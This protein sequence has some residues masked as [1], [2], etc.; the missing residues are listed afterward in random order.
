MLYKD[1]KGT[2]NFSLD[3]NLLGT[4]SNNSLILERI[5]LQ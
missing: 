3:K 2:R 1:C 5:P 4:I